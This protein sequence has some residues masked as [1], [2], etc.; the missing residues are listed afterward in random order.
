M[1]L[2]GE[3]GTTPATLP[4]VSLEPGALMNLTIGTSA[5]GSNVV[6]VPVLVPSLY[7]STLTPAGSGSPSPSATPT[8]TSSART[9]EPTTS[10]APGR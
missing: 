4:S 8:Q 7:Y 3:S 5:A 2:S 10:T 6:G 9:P 1:T